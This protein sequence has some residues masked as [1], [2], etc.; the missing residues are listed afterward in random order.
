MV[1]SWY[2]LLLRILL[3]FSKK[4]HNLGFIPNTAILC[5]IDMVGLYPHIPCNEGLYLLRWAMVN[6]DGEMYG[7]PFVSKLILLYMGYQ[8]KYI[9]SLIILNACIHNFCT[10]TQAQ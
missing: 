5:T 9:A 1:H 8:R 7:R 2:I 6:S 3:I 10:R 4:I